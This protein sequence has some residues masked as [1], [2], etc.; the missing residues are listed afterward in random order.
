MRLLQTGDLHLGKMFYD[1]S[2][3]EDQKYILDCIIDEL[4][5]AKKNYEPY[6]ALLICGDIYDRAI[7]PPDAVALFDDFLTTRKEQH[8][9][10]DIY[11]KGGDYHIE[12]DIPGFTKDEILY[13]NSQI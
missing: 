10:C 8:M 4:Q 13:I 2:L 12:M 7:P 11:E 1:Y 9:K 5:T 3:Y 6:D